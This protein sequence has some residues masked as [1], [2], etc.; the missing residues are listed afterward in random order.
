MEGNA[1]YLTFLPLVERAGSDEVSDR[2]VEPARFGEFMV[3]VFD[4]WKTG[5]IGKIKIQLFEEALRSAFGQEHTLCIFKKECGGVPAIEMDGNF[6]SCDHYV[7]P[8]NLV[9]N[10]L[11]SP[12]SSM[13]S[14]EK[15][16]V[17]GQMK[18]TSLPVY[19]RNC[20]VLGMCNGGCP[21]NRFGLTPSGEPGLNYLCAGYRMLF[22]H[23]KPFAET[24]SK[25]WGNRHV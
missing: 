7:N 4:L 9:G 6:Y 2:S 5:G 24:V 16:T 1:E 21:R 8:G 18:E 3:T 22:N 12:V 11:E 19:C 10:I 23:I 20:E 14:S 13:L 25:A 15:Q 17:F